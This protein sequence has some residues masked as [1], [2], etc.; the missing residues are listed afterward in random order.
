LNGER[1]VGTQRPSEPRWKNYGRLQQQS[2][3]ESDLQRYIG[4]FGLNAIGEGAVESILASQGEKQ[5]EAQ[6][7]SQED[8]QASV[9]RRI[10]ARLDGLEKSVSSPK[11]HQPTSSAKHDNTQ[12]HFSATVAEHDDGG[13]PAPG[14]DAPSTASKRPARQSDQ[15]NGGNPVEEPASRKVQ[16]SRQANSMEQDHTGQ[17]LPSDHKFEIQADDQVVTDRPR[18][19]QKR[20]VAVHQTPRLTSIEN[21]LA[22]ANS[23]VIRR[24]VDRTNDA[25]APSVTSKPNEQVEPADESSAGGAKEARTKG[26]RIR[27]NASPSM[28]L[29]KRLVRVNPP[30]VEAS[31]SSQRRRIEARDRLLA[32][33][34]RSRST[35]GTTSRDSAPL[36]LPDSSAPK[37]SCSTTT[38]SFSAFALD[39]ARLDSA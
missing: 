31:I 28:S 24:V 15:A 7:E 1:F 21:N 37:S 38:T 29:L 30:E 23:L 9:L 18:S 13:R 22:R 34:G 39:S 5:P 16:V 20:A 17:P 12:E 36:K 3:D 32:K 35:K 19:R 27:D 14:T 33:K 26:G 4:G 8:D 10:L 11:E 6:S 25:P 2:L